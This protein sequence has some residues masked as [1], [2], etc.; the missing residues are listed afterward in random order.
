[1]PEDR[2]IVAV[3]HL[4]I[5]VLIIKNLNYANNDNLIKILSIKII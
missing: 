1:M 5:D 4:R 2:W 3:D